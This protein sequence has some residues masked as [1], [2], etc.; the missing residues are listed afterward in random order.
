MSRSSEGV[1]V[2]QIV[3]HDV[4]N[5]GLS[6]RKRKHVGDIIK[7][8]C[9]LVSK[10]SERMDGCEIHPPTTQHHGEAF[11]QSLLSRPTH[12]SVCPSTTIKVSLWKNATRRKNQTCF[13]V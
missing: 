4:A 5:A 2:W 9:P 7:M 12:F 1:V 8:G 6:E 3:D 13:A 10:V 11:A